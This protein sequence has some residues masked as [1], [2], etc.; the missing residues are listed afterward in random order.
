MGAASDHPWFD[1]LP[2]RYVIGHRGAPGHRPEN[3]LQSFQHAVALGADVLE[4]DVHL[5]ADGQLVVIHDL[6]VGR[7]S[8]SAGPVIS[9]TLD[10]LRQLDVGYW[11]TPD[12][13]R[14]YP[15][16]GKGLT[17]PTLAEVFEMFPDRK[18]VIELKTR[19]FAVVRALAKELNKKD[20][21][22]QVLVGSFRH[23][24]LEEFRRL[25]PAYAT[26][27]SMRE[28]RRFVIRT[29]RGRPIEQP[30]LYEAIIAPP[31]RRG[32]IPVLTRGVVENALQIGLHVQAWTVN[33]PRTMHRLYGYGVHAMTTDY[34]DRARA[35]LDELRS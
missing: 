11:Y 20:R 31:R 6:V 24:L 15:W 19:T 18:L 16:R 25:A 26:G 22:G 32:I 23:P 29:L 17:V 21:R 7:V 14:T 27:A 33:K 35:V 13:G 2:E 34:P 12:G 1:G 28:T 3:T 9:F 5:T 4:L 30:L 8:N 10:D